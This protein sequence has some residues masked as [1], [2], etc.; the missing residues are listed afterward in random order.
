MSKTN[1]LAPGGTE[2]NSAWIGVRT[3]EVEAKYSKVERGDL[4]R[5]DGIGATCDVYCKEGQE[6]DGASA[7]GTSIFDPVLCELCYK[8]FI[9]VGGSILDPFAGGSVRGIVA[10]TLGHAYTGIDLSARQ[11]AANE[12]QAAGLC[13]AIKPTWIV[14]DSREV[15]ALLKLAG[16]DGLFDFVFACPPYYDLEV[17]SEDQR[18]LSVCSWLEFCDGY[19]RIITACVERLKLN[20]FA[21]FVIGDVRDKEGFYRKLPQLTVDCFEKAGMKLYNAAVLL[22]AVGSLPIRVG[23]QFSSGRKLGNTHQ[24][25]LCFFKGDPR[26]IKDDFPKLDQFGGEADDDDGSEPNVIATETAVAEVIAEAKNPKTTKPKAEKSS[27][28]LV[29]DD[30]WANWRPT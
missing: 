16:N 19:G 14:G 29:V 27:M 24:H 18:D 25:V 22:T 30:K 2:K 3:P 13:G 21:V 7:T 28:D 6:V 20:R 9:P 11:I 12:A 17:Y 1:K 8:W 23:K 26:K 15:A 5:K 4:D 10:A